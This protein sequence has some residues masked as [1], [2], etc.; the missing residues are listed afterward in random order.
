[1]TAAA[2]PLV[3]GDIDGDGLQDLSIVRGRSL[4]VWF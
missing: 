3:V 1:M 2:A 4:E